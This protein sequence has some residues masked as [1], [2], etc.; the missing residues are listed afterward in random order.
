MPLG[1]EPRWRDHLDVGL[2]LLGGSAQPGA[3][4]VASMQAIHARR[5]EHLAL[6]VA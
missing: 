3:P 4:S 2:Q 1:D 5:E 6:R